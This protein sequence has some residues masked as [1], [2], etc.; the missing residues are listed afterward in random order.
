M[1]DPIPKATVERLRPESAKALLVRNSH[2][3]NLR[4]ARVSALA[5]A[6]RRGE[7]ELNGESIKLGVDGTLLDGQHRL[8]AIVEAKV[9]VEVLIV[10]NLAPAVQDTVDTGRRRRLADIL[11][12]EGYTDAN[13]L[14]AALSILH[15]YRVG[16][17]LDYSHAN[18]PSAA[19]ALALIEDE[20]N[21]RQSV[22]VG[23]NV[24]KEIGGPIGVFSALH[25][26]FCEIDPDPA[27]DFF[28]R[29]KSGA[30]LDRND[31]V[32]RL[33]NQ[34]TR[35]RKDR[36]YTQ[37]P[38]HIAALTVKAFNL[39]RAGRGVSALLYRANEKFPTVEPPS[40]VASEQIL[41]A[42]LGQ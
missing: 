11:M 4:K 30:E 20:P 1:T 32:L 2:N 21:I 9:P 16:S 6:M 18:A 17:R 10:R 3:R 42:V 25:H 29:L 7:W 39:R 19:Q 8:Q 35:P 5:E 31:P 38:H 13:G 28:A 37:S 40:A 36:G 26:V 23:R 27:D 41:E 15:R 22:R 14:A 33:R 34:I 24:T 12:V